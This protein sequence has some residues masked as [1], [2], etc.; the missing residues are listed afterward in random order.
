MIDVNTQRTHR[1]TV[2]AISVG[3][4]LTLAA[5]GGGDDASS[6]AE[7]AATETAASESSES[8]PPAA[9]ADGAA[10]AIASF[11]FSGATE[12]AVGTTVTVT[13]DDS[14]THTWSSEDGTFDSG[15]IAPGESFEFTFDTAGTF[16]YHCNF[17]AS[18]QGTIT[19]TA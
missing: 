13:N 1:R 8:A 4:L 2:L 10:I 17:H 15:S 12:V 3:L 11:A 19:V 18:M 7:T 6:E 5:C 14:T 9:A 16:A